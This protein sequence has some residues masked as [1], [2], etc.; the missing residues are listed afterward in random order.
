MRTAAYMAFRVEYFGREAHAAASP[1]LGINALDA[2]ITAYAALSVLRQQNMPGDVIQG[3]ITDGGVRPNIIHAYAAGDFVV[4]ADT[5]ARLEELKRKVDNCFQ[6]GALASGATLKMTATMSYADHVPNRVLAHSYRRF[7]N[8]LAPPAQIPDNDDVDEL[9][10]KTMASTDQGNIS[11]AM[12]SLNAGFAIPAG[13]DG[14]GPHSPSFAEA[15]GTRVA[16]ERALRTGKALGATAVDVLVTKGR[17]EKV[18][19]TW[20]NDMKRRKVSI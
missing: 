18:Q 15:A 17:L 19:A 13:P 5:Q 10:G 12:P 6:A 2:L 7:F 8:A 9:H 1:W 4:R 20:A 11:Y 14:N 3:N 16:F